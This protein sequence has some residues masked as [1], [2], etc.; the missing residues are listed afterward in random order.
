MH[1]DVVLADILGL[2]TLARARVVGGHAGLRRPVRSVN[3]MEVPDI[4]EWVKP[5]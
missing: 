5:D 4:L 2:S 1:D 3:V